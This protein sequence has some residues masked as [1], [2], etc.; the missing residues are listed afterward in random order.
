MTH[1]EIEIK[2]V[3]QELINMWTLVQSQM[4]KTRDA[5]LHADKDLAREVIQREKR[6]NAL[7]LKIDRDCENVFALYCPVA[8][9]LRFLLAVLKINTNLERVG[10]IAKT[11]C[12]YLIDAPS[13]FDKQLL[14]ETKVLQM[15]NIVNDILHDTRVAFEHENTTLA[16][17]IFQKDEILDQIN[18]QSGIIISEYI[19]KNLDN[20]DEALYAHSIIKKLERIGDH[21]ENMAEEIIFYVEAKVL[22]HLEPKN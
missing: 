18:R 7:E 1:Q 16:R 8:V 10:D 5:M 4:S 11:I 14:E 21:S 3:K 20:I 13:C 6:V 17:S 2:A 12:K 9:D 19:H 22:K 15:I